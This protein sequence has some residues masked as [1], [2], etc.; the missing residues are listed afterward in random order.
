MKKKLPKYKKCFAWRPITVEGTWI[1]LEHYW[2]E[3]A[4]DSYLS[5]YS[6]KYLYDPQEQ[7]DA[8]WAKN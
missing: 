4:F 1:W 5:P 6:H 3:L 8:Y 7:I 2:V